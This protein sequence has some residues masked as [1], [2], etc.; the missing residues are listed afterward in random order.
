M[1]VFCFILDVFLI[2]WIIK[3]LCFYLI[4]IICKF[5]IYEYKSKE[6]IVNLM[7]FYKYIGKVNFEFWKFLK[8]LKIVCD[9]FG[10][11]EESIWM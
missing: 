2:L 10:C 7:V 11:K 9:I 6:N 3:L 8:G 4:L 5:V 1:I